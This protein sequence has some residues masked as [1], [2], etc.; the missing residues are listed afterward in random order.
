MVKTRDRPRRDGS[1]HSRRKRTVLR[2]A[3]LA[4]DHAFLPFRTP[5]AG[6]DVIGPEVGHTWSGRPV[7][8]SSR[9]RRGRGEPSTPIRIDS[10]LHR[11]RIG[12]E[13]AILRLAG[14]ASGREQPGAVTVTDSRPTQ[15]GGLRPANLRD[16]QVPPPRPRLSRREKPDLTPPPGT[17]SNSACGGFVDRPERM[18]DDSSRSSRS[19]LLVRPTRNGR[20]VGGRIVPGGPVPRRPPTCQGA[21]DATT[22]VARRGPAPA[23]RCPGRRRRAPGPPTSQELAGYSSASLTRGEASTCSRAFRAAGHVAFSV[24][25][26]GRS[27]ADTSGRTPGV[28]HTAPDSLRQHSEQRERN[29]IQRTFVATHPAPNDPAPIAS[30]APHTSPA[31]GRGK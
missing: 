20:R 3:R 14:I 13:C 27:T 21:A 1:V 16:T 6:A 17:D 23:R 31:P 28:A 30:S 2:T 4:D 12:A 26:P 10:R 8:D 29:V 25:R 18:S 5:R 24:D 11:A 22:T 7:G 15:A 9:R 19:R